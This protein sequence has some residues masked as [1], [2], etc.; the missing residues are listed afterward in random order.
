METLLTKFTDEELNCILTYKQLLENNKIDNFIRHLDVDDTF[1]DQELKK[2]LS[3]IKA[4]IKSKVD[5][6]GKKIDEIS[7]IQKPVRI[8]IDGVF[9]LVHSGHFNA[10]RQAK[11]LGDQLICGVNSDMDVL[12]VKGPTL[13][14]CS[15]RAALVKACKW[16]DEVHQD[17]PYTPTLEVLDMYQ[18]NY[19]SHGD[20]ICLDENGHGVYDEFIK[21]N[22][23]KIFKRT[24]GVSTTVIIGRLLMSLKDKI[25]DLDIDAEEKKKL[26]ENLEELEK[27]KQNQKPVMS[28]FLAT[29]WRI[30]EFS[31]HKLPSPTDKIIYICGDFDILHCGYI[32]ALESAKKEGDFLYVGVF[33]DET[34]HK[35]RGQNKNCP[36]LNM[37]ERVFNLLAMKNVDEIVFGAPFKIT[38]DMI[39]LLKIDKVI[40]FDCKSKAN[41]KEKTWRKL[42]EEIYEIP[43][44]MGIVK[45]INLDVELSND[46]LIEKLWTHKDLYL[47]KYLKKAREEMISIEERE[48]H[49][50]KEI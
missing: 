37:N 2:K 44:K 49:D 26:R 13:L 8:Y 29:S 39:R 35:Y 27:F 6:L 14:T 3:E 1:A 7:V 34:A 23:L 50:I 30:T 38:E 12:K 15:E 33:D 18:C 22:K 36:I 25:N 4:E 20:D 24:E 40:R 42:E 41:E 46:T 48:N 11:K 31:N 32:E 19:C 10:I 45:R 17:T 47:K 16:I 43:E 28:S 21:Q 9:D 5:E